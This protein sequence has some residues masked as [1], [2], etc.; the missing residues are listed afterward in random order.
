VHHSVHRI[1]RDSRKGH[2][3]ARQKHSISSCFKLRNT[4]HLSDRRCFCILV[5]CFRVVPDLRVVILNE[6]LA[7]YFPKFG[8]VRKLENAFHTKSCHVSKGVFDKN[9]SSI[10]PHLAN[11]LDTNMLLICH[12]ASATCSTISRCVASGWSL[13]KSKIVVWILG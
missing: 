5:A 2:C 12:P 6:T 9:S 4:W 3:V 13:M 7:L 11:S 1:T 8:D 10:N